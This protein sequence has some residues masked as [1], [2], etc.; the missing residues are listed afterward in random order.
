MYICLYNLIMNHI[1]N[2]LVRN[3]RII[4][5]SLQ[6]Q[7][8]S[9]VKPLTKRYI[10][11]ILFSHDYK[12]ILLQVNDEQ[13]RKYILKYEKIWQFNDNLEQNNKIAV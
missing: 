7:C 13:W 5:K 8:Y 4:L 9:V 11:D 3:N 1:Q 2:Y 6:N 10:K 12:K